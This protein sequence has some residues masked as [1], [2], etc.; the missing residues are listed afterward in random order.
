MQRGD[1][2]AVTKRKHLDHGA[3]RAIAVEQDKTQ[4]VNA[5]ATTARGT[6]GLG[7][8]PGRDCAAGKQDLV[9]ANRELRQRLTDS[10]LGPAG[11]SPGAETDQDR[12]GIDR[13]GADRGYGRVRGRAPGT[14]RT[15][16][17]AVLVDVKQD[18]PEPIRYIN[19]RATLKP[20]AEELVEEK[21][22]R[23]QAQSETRA[24]KQRVQALEKDLPETGWTPP[25]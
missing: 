18:V 6:G 20:A 9:K 25:G 21:E 8:H 1:P 17:A 7:Q 4:T 5:E 14:R 10:G 13:C 22:K 12:S 11:G 2:R 3:Y 24:A 19:V 23:Q 15:T 16:G